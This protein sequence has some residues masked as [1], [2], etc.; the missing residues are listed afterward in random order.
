[1]KRI[2]A[3]ATATAATALVIIAVAVPALAGAGDRH[4]GAHGWGGMGGPGGGFARICADPEAH[5]AGM[6]AFA[7]AKLDITDQQRDAWDRFGQAVRTAAQPDAE[8]CESL[9][10]D[11]RPT[12][13]PERL[14]RFQQVAEARLAQLERI[15]PAVEE[16]YAA[17]TPEQQETADELMAHGRRHGRR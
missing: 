5:I 13:L 7:E 3:T 15:R 16:M 12:T 6:L 2:L 17:L 4:A 9:A 10:Q 1:M 11:E 8:L 14:G